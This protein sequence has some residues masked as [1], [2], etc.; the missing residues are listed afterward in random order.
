[1]TLDAV[2]GR[3]WT[4][5]ARQSAG[6]VP[7]HFRIRWRVAGNGQTRKPSQDQRQANKGSQRLLRYAEEYRDSS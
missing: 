3:D 1:M 5:R 4:G 7:A 6:P 2:L